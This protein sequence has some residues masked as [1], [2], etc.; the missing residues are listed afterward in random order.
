M[1]RKEVAR[2]MQ[3]RKKEDADEFRDDCFIGCE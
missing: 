2:K 3:E 1:E